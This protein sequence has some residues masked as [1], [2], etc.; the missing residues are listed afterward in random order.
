MNDATAH[1]HI[2]V[3]LVHAWIGIDSSPP[4]HSTARLPVSHP[5]Q[6]GEQQTNSCNPQKTNTPQHQTKQ[7]AVTTEAM[8]FIV[9]HCSGVV[10]V[11]LEGPE[12]DRLKLPPMIVDNEV[13][14]FV[15]GLFRKAED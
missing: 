5:P 9:R 8:A 6:S 10:C 4:P 1:T 2:F 14:R 13:R 15:L 3:C 12:L 7:D 11:S